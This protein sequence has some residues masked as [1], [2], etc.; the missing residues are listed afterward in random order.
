MDHNKS[1]S[2]CMANQNGVSDGKC[3]YE[4]WGYIL[5]QEAGDHLFVAGEQM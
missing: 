1:G 2:K 3:V 4:I 5:L